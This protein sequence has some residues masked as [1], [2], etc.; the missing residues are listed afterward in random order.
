MTRGKTYRS[1]RLLAA[2][3]GLRDG[4]RKPMSTRS[5]RPTGR[6]LLL[7]FLPAVL[8]L[9]APNS[10]AQG[11]KGVGLGKDAKQGAGGGWLNNPSGHTFLRMR[12]EASL[13]FQ[14]EQVPQTA[15]RV[16]AGSPKLTASLAGTRV[17]SASTSAAQIGLM[18]GERDGPA[19]C[20][21]EL[22][23]GFKGG[24]VVIGT[25]TRMA[26]VVLP[27]DRKKFFVDVPKAIQIGRITGLKNIK[28]TFYAWIRGKI[29]F[30]EILLKVDARNRVVE[31][32]F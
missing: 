11:N 21:V 15:A 8:F 5:A 18:L 6:A 17:R 16:I 22:P 10:V 31:V 1:V 30:F 7:L 9:L 20:K 28:L 4:D 32:K 12:T 14:G 25:D 27:V 24:L 13:E 23:D 19:R 26:P 29:A 3:Y 2:G